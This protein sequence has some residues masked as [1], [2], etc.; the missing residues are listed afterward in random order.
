MQVRASRRPRVLYDVEPV[1]A[2]WILTEDKVPESVPH[3]TESERTRGLLRRRLRGL[4]RMVLVAR[5]LA[6]RWDEAHR[7]IGIDPDV[8]VIEP[9]P[10]EGDELMS[11]RLWEPGHEAPV[12]AVEI[13]SPSRPDKDYGES[14]EKY[15]ACGTRELW[16][17]D[18]KLAGPKKGGGPYRLQLWR[19]DDET[20]TFERRY[21]GEGPFFSEEIGGWV[22]AANEGRSLAIADDREGTAWW[23]T[24]EEA[25]RAA[26]EQAELEAKEARA[27]KE[28]AEWEADEARRV[29]E[30]ERAAREAMERRLAALEAELAKRGT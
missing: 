22:F 3:D 26:R 15:A 27:A 7:S 4:G 25:E 20:D 14:P 28:Q 16:V 6:V 17:F 21:A 19:R 10:P 12:L 5:N 13:V 9:P 1:R 8:C 23:M 11:L 24:D 2:D 30:R 29:A 18:P